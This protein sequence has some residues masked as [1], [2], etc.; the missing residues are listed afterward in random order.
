MA[1]QN[2]SGSVYYDLP[3]D[4][5]QFIGLNFTL[6]PDLGEQGNDNWNSTQAA[7]TTE[8]TTL[9]DRSLFYVPTGLVV[10]LSVLYG[11]ISIISVMGNALVILVV[12]KNRSMHT[13]TNFFISNLAF[14]DVMIGMFSIPFQFQ[15]AM[16]QRWDL[17]YIMCPVAPFVKEVSVNVSVVTLTVISI[18]RFFAV[19]H[20]LKPRC[21]GRVAKIVMTFVWVFSIGSAIPTAIVFKLKMVLGDLP[22]EP[23]KPFCQPLYPEINNVDLGKCYRLYLLIVQYFFPLLIISFA[24]FRIMYRIWGNKAPGSALNSR[25]QMLNKNKRKV[26]GACI[27][28]KAYGGGGRGGNKI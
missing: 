8:N 23:L 10:L 2:A 6:T 27:F 3:F 7:N 13:V 17:P 5:G 19:I 9:I 24:Y 11:I 18:D 25:D 22:G 16:L 28:I 15:A 1:M 21:S 26:G 12:Y 14:A 20:P 4:G